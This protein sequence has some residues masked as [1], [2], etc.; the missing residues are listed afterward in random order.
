MSDYRVNFFSG[1]SWLLIALILL[2][3][4]LAI[5]YFRGKDSYVNVPS[6]TT[7]PS[8]QPR[9]YS[10]FYKV[11]V[12]GPT[13][14]RIHMGDSV[15]FENDSFTSV[16]VISDSVSKKLVLADF[17]SKTDIPPNQSFTYTF[18]KIGIF[19]YHNYNNPDENGS[20][21]VRP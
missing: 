2:S 16:R 21:I 19:G 15:R 8:H 17:D 18:S 12:F 13:N 6:S 10:V 3:L 14:I 11:G 7:M 9:E 5:S 20:V 1:L 4:A